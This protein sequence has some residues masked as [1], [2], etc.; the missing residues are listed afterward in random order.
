MILSPLL[1]LVEVFMDLQQP[2]LM[3][4]IVDD[5]ILAMN[6]AGQISSDMGIIMTTSIKM[7]ICA[8]VG[9]VGG[10]GCTYFSS[11]ASQNFGADLRADVFRKISSF[12][13]AET[14]KLTEVF[15]VVYLYQ[16]LVVNRVLFRKKNLIP[17]P[18]IE[19]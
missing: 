1:M 8:L 5:G 7:L 10:V 17:F 11:K 19:S 15:G 12:S 16:E 6:E 14:D 2:T 3:S 18:E 9:M 13:F 4:T